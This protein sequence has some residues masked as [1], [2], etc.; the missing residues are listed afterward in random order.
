MRM[1]GSN[2]NLSMRLLNK[3][4]TGEMSQCDIEEYAYAVAHHVVSRCLVEQVAPQTKSLWVA[5]ES[6]NERS[7]SRFKRRI[8]VSDD[9]NDED[10][11]VVVRMARKV[12]R[13][14]K[15][16]RTKN[17]LMSYEQVFK[18]VYGSGHDET[19]IASDCSRKLEDIEKSF[20]E[21]HWNA[22]S[23][24]DADVIP[25][26]HILRKDFNRFHAVMSGV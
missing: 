6:D 2:I 7:K 19:L 18:M 22:Y 17:M 4:Y 16:T 5:K 13:T 20:E 8:V 26:G 10:D 12:R 3:V 25:E 1:T 11:E 9:E 24:F 15:R 23:M 21:E 14:N